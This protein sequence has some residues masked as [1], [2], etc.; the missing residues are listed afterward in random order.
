MRSSL[1]TIALF[2]TTITWFP[3]CMIHEKA[4]PS[5]AREIKEDVIG[6]DQTESR[7]YYFTEAQIQQKR[8]NLDKAIMYLNQAIHTD[9]ESPYLQRELAILYIK[10]KDNTRALGILEQVIEKFPKDI[11]SLIIYGKL[12]QGL[13]NKEDAKTAYEKV[14]TIDP[15][16]QDVYLFLGGMYMQDNELDKALKNYQRLIHRFPQSYV[17]HFF[18]GKIYLSQGKL[19]DAEDKFQQT[20]ALNPDLEEPHFEL[21]TIYKKLGKEKKVVQLYLDILQKNPRNV[22][23]GLELGLVYHKKGLAEASQ[24]LFMELGA[25][26]ILE[27]EIVRQVI[28]LYLDSKQY[29][30]AIVV[31]QGMLQGAPQSSDLFYIA[32]IAYDGKK[33]KDSAIIN[34]KKVAPGSRFYKDA[35]VQISFIYQEQ[36]KIEQAIGYLEGVVQTIPDNPEFLLYLGSFYEDT[37]AY[38]KAENVLKQGLKVD[39]SN[40]RLHFRLGVVYD[41]WGRK[42]ESIEA[43]KA[44]IDLDPK[45]ANAL[46]YLGYT[47]AELGENL[48]EAERLIKAAL[49]EKPDDGYITDSLGWVY[50]KKR[51]FTKALKY[52]EKAVTLVPDDPTILEHLGDVYLEISNKEKA[53]EFYQRS[54]R[55]KEK[56]T[57]DLEKKIQGLMGEE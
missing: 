18:I 11:Q 10:K 7:Y 30:D 39:S 8:G 15:Q 56:D 38:E 44:V 41:K 20:L 32:G 6:A 12:N 14:L 21:L 25:R 19:K 24:K 13:N 22:R 46:N 26:S 3:G 4:P 40:I 50:F 34:F 23:A 33:D 49:K 27:K 43:M 51:L 28:Q 2:F 42:L 29:N 1:L 9:P 53:L 55:K 16:Q 45:H 54:L 36:E 57:A 52:L 5:L 31:L 37:N 35:V 17:G 48:D 47:Y